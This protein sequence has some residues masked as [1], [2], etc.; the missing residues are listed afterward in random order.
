MIHP[1]S[2]CDSLLKSELEY[3]Q[4]VINIFQGLQVFF[5]SFNPDF[6]IVRSLFA[7]SAFTTYVFDHKFGFP[8]GQYKGSGHTQYFPTSGM[9]SLIKHSTKGGALFWPAWSCGTI[10]PHRR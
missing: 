9:E 5:L 1:Y 10:N 7:C 8:G 4:E 3:T 6:V 2:V